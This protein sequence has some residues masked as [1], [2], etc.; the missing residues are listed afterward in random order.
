MVV[1]FL[2]SV[3]NKHTMIYRIALLLHDTA[4]PCGVT[5]YPVLQEIRF[6]KASVVSL[7]QKQTYISTPFPK[8]NR[9]IALAQ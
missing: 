7:N 8:I 4:T 3:A 5:E 6:S 1:T 2:G 9:K